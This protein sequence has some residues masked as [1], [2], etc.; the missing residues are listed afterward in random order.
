MNLTR[1]NIL[2]ALGIGAAVA[3]IPSISWASDS[4]EKII[5]IYSIHDFPIPM[6]GVITLD[7]ASYRIHNTIDIGGA[8][9]HVTNCHFITDNSGPVFDTGEHSIFKTPPLSGSNYLSSS[10]RAISNV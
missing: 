9:L 8:S 10:I 3:A 7:S 2:K 1:R 5:D 6:N 4:H